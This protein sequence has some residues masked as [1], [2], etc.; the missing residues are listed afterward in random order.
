M[1]D[2][3]AAV[4]L[5]A[6]ALLSDFGRYIGLSSLTFGEQGFVGLMFDDHALN[7]LYDGSRDAFVI[8]GPLGS[9]P[10]NDDRF[11]RRLSAEC[12]YSVFNGEGALTVDEQHGQVVWSDIVPLS[13]LT[14]DRFQ[15]KLK[16]AVD[17]IEFLK[18]SLFEALC[19]G[20]R[21][22]VVI[23]NVTGDAAFVRI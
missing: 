3:R 1:S 21:D 19:R 8:Y 6:E 17:Q 20:D 12:H 18:G 23:S 16:A 13:D 22:R 9:I 7:I 11:F 15:E 4:S 10:T 14:Q 5:D 2:V